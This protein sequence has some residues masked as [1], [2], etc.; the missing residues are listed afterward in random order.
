[1]ARVDHDLRPDAL[2]G[3]FLLAKEMRR[4]ISE[5]MAE[6]DWAASAG[7]R[8]PCLGVMAV[9]AKL[10]PVSQREISDHLGLD[11]SDVVGVLD[12][13]EAAHLVQR[14]RDPADRR[15][16]AVV[17]TEAGEAA[18]RHFATLRAEAEARALADLNPDERR[19]LVDLLNRATARCEASPEAAM[20]Q[21]SLSV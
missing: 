1:M 10:Q 17:L 9:V 15:R 5:L 14:R 19:Q 3:V 16:H 12:I 18:A 4:H 21:R 11:A 20:R 6:E 8:P 2:S 7:F 13:L